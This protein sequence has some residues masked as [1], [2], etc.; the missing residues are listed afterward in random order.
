M[1]KFISLPVEKR[2]RLAPE[3]RSPGRTFS[4]PSRLTSPTWASPPLPWH[5]EA[6]DPRWGQP[7]TTPA[8]SG[9]LSIQDDVSLGWRKGAQTPKPGA[10]IDFREITVLLRGQET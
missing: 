3:T 5:L 10:C 7:P 1:I 2:Q 8:R 6:E 4:H 9:W